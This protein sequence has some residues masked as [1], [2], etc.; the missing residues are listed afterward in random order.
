MTNTTQLLMRKTI[1]VLFL[2]A[3][4]RGVCTVDV[5]SGRSS[6]VAYVRTASGELVEQFPISGGVI[7][8]SRGYYRKLENEVVVEGVYASHNKKKLQ[9]KL[10][11][12][13]NA[14][15]TAFGVDPC[16][17]G[18]VTPVIKKEEGSIFDRAQALRAR[19]D[20]PVSSR[21]QRRVVRRRRPPRAQGL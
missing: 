1:Y 21:G 16:A 12:V 9:R 17:V 19:S 10:A 6:G 4:H 7:C 14:W 18:V 13:R 15:Q 2:S 20:T 3:L 11:A 5:K 8:R